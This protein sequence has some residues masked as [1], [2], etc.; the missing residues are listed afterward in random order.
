MG[1]LLEAEFEE[2]FRE[3]GVHRLHLVPGSLRYLQMQER[4]R[5]LFSK[6]AF[7]NSGDGWLPGFG[8]LKM[9]FQRM[10]KVSS[11]D[12]FGLDELILFSFYADCRKRY[13]KFADLGAN[14]GLHS[15]LA[16]L[17]GWE[18]SAYEPDDRTVK[19][20]EA[21]FAANGVSIA[22]HNV[23]VGR[24]L[25]HQTFTRVEH[26]LTGSHLSGRKEVVT[27]P[28]S[29]FEVT[30]VPFR[31]ILLNHDLLKIDVEGAEGELLCSTS[32]TDW[33]GTDA[34]LEVGS[35]RTAEEIYEHVT[36]WTSV[37]LFSQKT[38]WKKVNKYE[39]LP[40]HH[41]QGSVYISDSPSGELARI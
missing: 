23:A 22:I 7:A 5:D 37:G 20:A 8:G 11:L 19:I 25:G 12:L 10:G 36:N 21:N 40:T 39:D 35:E 29:N 33:S 34:F 38:G 30:T 41:T 6:S 15:I 27:G 17:L 31:D 13:S 16:A 26:N 18:V 1:K 24:S 32:E 28:F 14:I 9:P 4:A 3:I 2:L